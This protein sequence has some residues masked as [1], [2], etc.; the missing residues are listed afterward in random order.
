MDLSLI[1]P[2]RRRH[3]RLGRISVTIADVVGLAL[4][5]VVALAVILLLFL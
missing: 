1:G 3:S 4:G 2:D 5:A